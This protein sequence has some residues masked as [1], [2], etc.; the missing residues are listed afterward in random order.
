MNIQDAKFKK[1]FAGEY[2]I[3]GTFKGR[4]VAIQASR[5]DN[6]EFSWTAY[7]D[8]FYVDGDRGWTLGYLKQIVRLSP[9]DF[10][11]EL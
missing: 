4:E 9:Q 6:G 7:V 2:R 10:F 1:Q 5:Q 8:G 11:T 3:E